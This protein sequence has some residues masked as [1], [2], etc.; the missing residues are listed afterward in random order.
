MA[1]CRYCGQQIPEGG[2]CNCEQAVAAQ[3]SAAVQEV[4]K[5]ENVQAEVQQT[6][7]EQGAPQSAPQAAPQQGTA[8]STSPQATPG[9]DFA[10]IVAG[11]K[12]FALRIFKQPISTLTYAWQS[13]NVLPQY[14]IGII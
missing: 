8:Q 3:Q 4:P 14:A 1:F 12:D 11:V 2:S 10:P 7:S 5:T 6:V 13:P 9:F